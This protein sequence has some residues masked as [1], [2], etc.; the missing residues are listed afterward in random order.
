[1]ALKFH[2]DKNGNTSEATAKFQKINHAYHYL[3]HSYEYLD[4]DACKNPFKTYDSNTFFD[5]VSSYSSEESKNMYTSLLS[6]FVSSMVN[7]DYKDLLMCIIKEIVLNY[8]E[9]SMSNLETSG[10]LKL[11]ENVDKENVLEIYIFLNKY[12]H[13]LY[14]SQDILEFVSLIVK[15]KYKNDRVFILNPSISDIL[16]NNI[17]KLIVDEKLYLVPLWHSELY[18]D[19]SGNDIIVIC[20]PELCNELT[21]DEDNNI[22]YNLLVHLDNNLLLKEFITFELGKKEFKIPI[23]KLYIQK[24]QFYT[25]KKE[26]IAKIIEDDIYNVEHKGDVIIKIKFC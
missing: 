21:I 17:Y 10:L 4:A 16:E 24:E 23:K 14:I 25:I 3:E 11:F 5:F 20:N 26:G 2:P 15:E 22:L 8:C 6:V 13:I 9:L 12:K 18:F 19:A 1:M 7:G